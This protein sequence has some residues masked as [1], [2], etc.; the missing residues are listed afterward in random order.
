MSVSF[1]NCQSFSCQYYLLL[2]YFLMKKISY[3]AIL[4]FVFLLLMLL[5]RMLIIMDTTITVIIF[6]RT[7]Y[8]LHFKVT[9]NIFCFESNIENGFQENANCT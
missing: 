5:S 1:P 7:E 3:K 9:G 4:S 2:S 8:V 6:L